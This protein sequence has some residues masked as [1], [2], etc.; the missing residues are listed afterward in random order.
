MGTVGISFD[1]FCRC[2]MEE[3]E[4]IF[5]S[6]RETKEEDNKGKWERMRL[7]AVM[8]MQPHCKKKLNPHQI[9]PFPWEKRPLR[10]KDAPVVDKATA[11]RRFEEL[12]KRRND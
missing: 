9:L 7:H 11:K 6:W 2:T 12:A 8:V 3:L 10:K 1:D 4:A 5:K